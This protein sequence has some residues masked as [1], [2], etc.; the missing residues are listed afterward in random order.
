MSGPRSSCC[1]EPAVVLGRVVA[2]DLRLVVQLVRVADAREEISQRHRVESRGVHHRVAVQCRDGAGRV[3]DDLHPHPVRLLLRG[4]DARRAVQEEPPL[5]GDPLGVLPPVQALDQVEVD[6]RVVRGPVVVE[7]LPAHGGVGG[8]EVVDGRG[9][10]TRL[11][12][13][14]SSAGL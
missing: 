2:H 3:V 9:S 13:G 5:P 8:E 1:P 10:K 6:A 11:A 7:Q 14:L 12:N 4:A